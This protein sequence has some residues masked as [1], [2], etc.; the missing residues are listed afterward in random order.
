MLASTWAH[1]KRSTIVVFRLKRINKS[2][3]LKLS[4][5]IALILL[6]TIFNTAQAAPPFT[7][8]CVDIISD[9]AFK[10]EIPA[11]GK[12]SLKIAR[13]FPV[14]AS[15]KLRLTRFDSKTSFRFGSEV[16]GG[17]FRNGIFYY[18]RHDSGTGTRVV[19][20]TCRII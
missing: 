6:P 1:N 7:F 10:F 8:R 13:G 5:I 12:G 4:Q 3:T 14:R 16:E 18:H 15:S 19:S 2:S 17:I 9:R 20:G 11:D